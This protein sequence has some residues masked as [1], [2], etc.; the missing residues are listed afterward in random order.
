MAPL[1][2]HIYRNTDGTVCARKEK[3]GPQQYGWFRWQDGK[4]ISGLSGKAPIYHADQVALNLTIVLTEGER[5]AD[6]LT[7]LGIC[8]SCGPNGASW[9]DEWADNFKG[10]TVYIC[11]DLDAK[12][13]EYARKAGRSLLALAVSVKIIELPAEYEHTPIKDVTDLYEVAGDEFAELWQ[14][15]LDSAPPFADF[16]EPGKNGDSEAPKNTLPQIISADELCAKDLL[17]PLQVIGGLLHQGAKMSLGGGSKSFKTWTLLQMAICIATKRE[18][19][20]FETCGQP[21]IYINLELPEWSIRRRTEVICQAM[22]IPVPKELRFWN[23]RGYSCNSEELFSKLIKEIDKYG[24]V[25]GFLDPIYK[26][27]GTKDEN[28]ARDVGL[29]LNALEKFTVETQMS[30][31]YGAHFS[32]GN[33]ST[34]EA[35]DRVSGSGVYARDPDSF[36]TLTQHQSENCFVLDM[37]LRDFPP[38]IPFVVKREHP[39]MIRD[40]QKDPV[41]LKQ[42][43]AANATKYSQKDILE[44][45][46]FDVPMKTG[47]ICEVVREETG[48]SEREFY[49]LWATLKAALLI[50]KLPKGWVKK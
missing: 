43:K 39:L 25:G 5:D 26:I 20:G 16:H 47:Q 35:L 37:I 34:K 21:V 30:V 42:A 18:W 32:K 2:Q 13:Q 10:K 33:Q 11:P 6:T 9:D 22:N 12:G 14:D 8:A 45:I 28:S 24:Y 40:E 46:G 7:K 44:H 50:Q 17:E 48:M 3:Y 36:L 29:I 49:E 41:K 27:L 38:Q 23:L 15:L 31:I 19:V 4:F 1:R